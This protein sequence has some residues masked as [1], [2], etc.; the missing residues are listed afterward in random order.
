M[1]I[2]ALSRGL[3]AE[4]IDMRIVSLNRLRLPHS[5]AVQT[6]PKKMMDLS[7]KMASE[8]RRYNH[9]ENPGPKAKTF[10]RREYKN[11]FSLYDIG[12]AELFLYA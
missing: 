3:E 12:E 7:D 11:F 9:G 5:S 2:P 6:M 4:Q 10:S 8:V 1:A